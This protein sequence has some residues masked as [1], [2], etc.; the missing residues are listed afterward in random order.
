MSFSRQQLA[1][2]YR[3]LTRLSTVSAIH[4]EIQMGSGSY[5]SKQREEV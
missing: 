3:L 2:H 4:P 5:V 1:S